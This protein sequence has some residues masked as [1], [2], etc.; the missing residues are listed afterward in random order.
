MNA[1]TIHKRQAALLK[2]IAHACGYRSDMFVE[3]H[4]MFGREIG[5]NPEHKFIDPK[6]LDHSRNVVYDLN[7]LK[8]DKLIVLAF[9]EGDHRAGQAKEWPVLQVSRDGIN[10]VRE[11]DRSWLSKA[12]EKQPMT[13][14]QVVFA[15]LNFIGF[16]ANVY[17]AWRSSHGGN[18]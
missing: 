13:F 7:C 5:L 4:K 18:Q 11:N 14:L 9:I 16:A 12:I 1:T 2:S 3:L 17:F 6:N 10:V 8:T 15:I